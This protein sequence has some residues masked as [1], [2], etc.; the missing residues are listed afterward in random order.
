M[1]L[2]GKSRL[3]SQFR[4]VRPCYKPVGYLQQV[5]ELL[6]GK[7]NYGNGND[8]D[9]KSGKQWSWS[10]PHAVSSNGE[11]SNVKYKSETQLFGM[12]KVVFPTSIKRA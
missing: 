4:A 5:L 9:M 8:S 2:P 3:Q 11:I 7:G 12:V 6:Y 10:E 1:K